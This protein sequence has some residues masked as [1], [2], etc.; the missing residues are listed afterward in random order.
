MSII[1]LFVLQL[2]AGISLMW[3]LAPRGQI[4]WGFFRIQMLLVLGLAVLV[5]LV[6]GRVP[7]D[8]SLPLSG[9]VGWQRV[10]MI[11]VA[12]AAYVG[13]VL[14][15]LDR[16]G[17]GT[18]CI[19]LIAA[20]SGWAV[21]MSAWGTMQPSGLGLLSAYSTAAVLGGVV[22]GMLLG[23]WYLTAPTMSIAP[24][25]RL[26]WFLTAAVLVRLVVS[27]VGWSL[28]EGSL[29]G[30]LIWTWFALRWLAGIL[31]PLVL[32]GMTLRILRYRNTQAATG[33]LFAAVILSF[34]GEMSAA[35]LAGE[36]QRPL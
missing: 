35:L 22:T 7:V 24:L 11:P 19:A 32:C 16:R 26:T 6:A 13:S 15:T 17:A 3:C 31:A 28:A 27:A 14:W 23:H 12:V 1:S 25:S 2:I 21:L 4:T 20:L 18:V 36:L 29:Q 8:E 9:A 34:I 5:L 10:L 33:V 30:S